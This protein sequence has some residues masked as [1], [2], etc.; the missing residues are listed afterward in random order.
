MI[1]IALA[2][3]SLIAR[4]ALSLSADEAKQVRESI[5]DCDPCQKDKSRGARLPTAVDTA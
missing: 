5:A 3:R 1:S 4:K 2:P